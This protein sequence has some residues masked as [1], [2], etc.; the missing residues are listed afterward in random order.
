MAELVLAAAIFSGIFIA[1]YTL[2]RMFLEQALSWSEALLLG[3]L[4]ISAAV[5]LGRYGLS[6]WGIP[7]VV[8]YLALLGFLPYAQAK[9]RGRTAH[10]LAQREI[11]RWRRTIAFDPENVG[12]YVFLAQAYIELGDLP[13]ALDA[14]QTALRLRPNDLRIRR[15]YEKLLQQKRSENGA[16][17]TCLICRCENS[18]DASRC[19]R[20]GAPAP[21]TVK[22]PSPLD[23]YVPPAALALAVLL[24]GLWLCGVLGTGLLLGLCLVLFVAVFLLFAL[25]PP[26]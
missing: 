20:C 8:L 25:R 24:L 26:S 13:Q 3:A 7:L 19:L 22:K 2:P 14:Y 5:F 15:E 12:A 10:A 17:W 4:V 21:R 23:R 11:A 9:L 1:F 6:P 18:P 16:G